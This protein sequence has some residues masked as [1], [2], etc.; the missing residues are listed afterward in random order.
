MG[1]KVLF[2]ASKI[3]RHG[4]EIDRTLDTLNRKLR[5][6]VVRIAAM[7]LNPYW[8]EAGEPLRKIHNPL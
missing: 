3:T 8:D 5:R 6:N 1:L 2:S 4:H 7:G